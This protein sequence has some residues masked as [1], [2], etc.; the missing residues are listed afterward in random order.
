MSLEARFL[1]A[2]RFSEFLAGAQQLATLWRDT[3]RVT[4]VPDDLVARA[5]ALPGRWHLL[6]LVEDWCGDAVNTVPY[7][8]RLA[9]LSP[10]LDLR[11][12]GRDANPDLM[13]AHLSPTGARAIPV[14]IVLDETFTERGWWGSRPSALQ[15]WFDETGRGLE[16]GE[17]YREIRGWYVRDRGRSTLDEVL[18]IVEDAAG[19]RRDAAA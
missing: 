4:R 18:A 17:R 19:T 14:V 1:A 8:A 13:D 3:Y 10:N 7:V 16:K 5:R 6:V 9:E 15:R 11:V 2:P 12:L